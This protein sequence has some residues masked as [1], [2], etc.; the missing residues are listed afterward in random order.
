MCLLVCQKQNQFE[1]IFLKKT[2]GIFGVAF[3]ELSRNT[4]NK[5]RPTLLQYNK[6]LL[7]LWLKKADLFCIIGLSE[8]IAI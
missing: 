2:Y 7:C 4:A 6:L 1:W 3:M 8:W 5:K